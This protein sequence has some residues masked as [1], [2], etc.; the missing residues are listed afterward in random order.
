MGINSEKLNQQEVNKKQW[1]I[2]AAYNSNGGE[3]ELIQ[4]I[5]KITNCEAIFLFGPN[6]NSL[7]ENGTILS[8][9]LLLIY[10][11]SKNGLIKELIIHIYPA[12]LKKLKSK[13]SVLFS[14]GGVIPPKSDVLVVNT[15]PRYFSDNINFYSNIVFK[16]L[17]G[18]FIWKSFS[19]FYNVLYKY[20]ILKN[21]GKIF[22][23]SENVKTR[24]EKYYN[25][26]SKVM[27]QGIDQNKYHLGNYEKYFVSIGRIA[28]MKQLEFLV[29]AFEIFSRKYDDYRLILIGFVDT[30]TEMQYRN[31]IKSLIYEKKMNVEIKENVSEDEKNRYLK[32][33]LAFLFSAKNEDFGRVL[34]EA[35]AS[36]K[37]IISIN[38]GG[39]IEILKDGETGYLISSPSE[40]AKKM[41]YLSLNIDKAKEMGLRGRLRMEENFSEDKFTQFLKSIIK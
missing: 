20:L 21:S 33:S 11:H 36:Y 13:Y 22:A 7:I 34:I 23:V 30:K 14:T 41:E 17:L 40:M 24:L 19:N 26:P 28:P 39:P 37:P 10:K 35:M 29:N 15:P 5:S 31:K 6:S 8:K 16:G 3:K 1:L 12:T 38:E 32:D 2:I 4:N 25:I 27:Y 18:R 9:M